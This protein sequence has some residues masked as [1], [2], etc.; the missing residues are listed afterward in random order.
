MSFDDFV[1]YH[2]PPPY[3][4]IILLLLAL[5]GLGDNLKWQFA[6]GIAYTAHSM[7]KSQMAKYKTKLRLA[8]NCFLM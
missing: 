6:H 7:N 3:S 8:I 2:L 5:W 1:I 4:R